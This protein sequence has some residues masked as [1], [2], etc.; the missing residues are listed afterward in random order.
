[1]SRL[2]SLLPALPTLA[3]LALASTAEAACAQRILIGGY[4]S[5]SVSVFDACTGTFE[6]T[7]DSGN[8][9]VGPQAM[10]IGPD[11]LLY[12]VSE[13]NGQILR[14]NASTLAF[15]DSFIN[16][17]TGFN[18]TG[19][20]FG[21]DGDVYVGGYEGDSV[22]RYDRQ[23]GALKATVVAA[24][25]AGL[26]GPDNGMSFGPDGR[27]Y[28]P[29]YDANTIVAWDPNS[30]QASIF[31]AR[32]AG[33]LF[34]PRGI[35]FEANGN[36]LVSSEGSGK[37]LR[38]GT[39]GAFIGVFAENLGQPTGM[40]WL[41]DGNLLVA[42][43]DSAIRVSAQ[44]QF[45]GLIGASGTGGLSGAT[46]AISIANATDTVTQVG[47]Q[48][49]IVGAGTIANKI[50]QAEMTSAT[51]TAFG[52]AFNPADIRNAR[53]GSVRIAFDSC[54]TGQVS[55][56]ST[57]ANAAGFGTG[58]YPI[59]LLLGT[60]FT[61]QCEATGFAETTTHDWMNGVWYGG[62]ARNGEGFSVTVSE[63]GLAAVAFYTHRP[64]VNTSLR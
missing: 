25:A 53:W 28:I 36:M 3:L 62:D 58:G 2:K 54:T 57:G 32:A 8:H 17:G 23:T 41:P 20:A 42:E 24:G 9:I 37:I 5:N 40:S 18:P 7:L 1:M 30:Q 46:F 61:T 6:R 55:W 14:Y 11:G 39:T 51:G 22:R 13:G 43:G 19:M 4:F 63:G 12:V 44:G 35:V 33:G 10:R 60:R 59:R 64:V 29:A 26:N 47:T 45:L 48:Y 38:Y 49:W 31:V 52:A 50:V 15:Q 16:T 56:D 27:L 21:P 34:R